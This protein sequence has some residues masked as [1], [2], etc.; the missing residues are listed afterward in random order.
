MVYFCCYYF[1]KGIE[2]QFSSFVMLLRGFTESVI[3]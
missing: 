2:R 1:C 3:R